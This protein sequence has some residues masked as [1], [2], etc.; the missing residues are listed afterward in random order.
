MQLYE[1][2]IPT[3][4]DFQNSKILTESQIELNPEEIVSLR[5]YSMES[6][7]LLANF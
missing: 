5:I 4:E 3:A 1:N 6:M 7:K 2:K